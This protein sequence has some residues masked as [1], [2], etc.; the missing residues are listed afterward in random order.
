MKKAAIELETIVKIVIVL[1]ALILIVMFLTG[2]FLGIG[3]SISN[4]T[5]NVTGQAPGVTD[6]ILTFNISQG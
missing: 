6:R 2:N 4:V 3:G 5:Q 1:F